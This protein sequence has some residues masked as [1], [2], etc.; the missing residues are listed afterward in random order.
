MLWFW[1]MVKYVRLAIG[2]TTSWILCSKYCTPPLDGVCHG[3]ELWFDLNHL[4]IREAAGSAAEVAFTWNVFFALKIFPSRRNGV[5]HSAVVCSAEFPKSMYLG[6]LDCWWVLGCKGWG[7][8]VSYRNIHS[9]K[10]YSVLARGDNS[11]ALG[12]VPSGREVWTLGDFARCYVVIRI[13]EAEYLE[14]I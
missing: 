9:Y 1:S 7:K 6:I 10:G 13:Y 3:S 4:C 14:Q 2:V 12:S 11:G 5:F 8:A